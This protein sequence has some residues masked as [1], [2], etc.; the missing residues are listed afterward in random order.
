MASFYGSIDLMKVK[1]AKLLSGLNEKYPQMNYVCI[2]CVNYSGVKLMPHRNDDGVSASLS[3]NMWPVSEKYRQTIIANRASRGED[4]TKYNPPSHQLEVHYEEDFVE[5]AK[6]A[7]RKRILK[8]H[9][10]WENAP[11]HEQELK[12]AVYNA[13]RIRLGNIYAHIAR[14]QQQAYTSAA[15]AATG[16]RAYVPPTVDAN[17]NPIDDPLGGAPMEDDDL[18]F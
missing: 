4:V 3:L 6:E 15:P 14:E 7:A 8:E 13:V 16:A 5:K 11:E 2:P 9:P 12:N 10:D 17:G 1:G 18:P